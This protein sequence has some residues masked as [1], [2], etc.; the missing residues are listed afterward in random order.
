MITFP[1]PTIVTKGWGYEVW[2]HNDFD[3]CGKILHFEE[4]KACS[5]HL[6][7]R[8][9]ETWYVLSGLF[10]LF[11]TDPKTGEALVKTLYPKDVI[12]V[13]QGCVHRLYCVEA[14]DIAEFSTE[15]RDDD[16][17]RIDGGDSQKNKT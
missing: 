13:P 14:G 4:D 16:S 11:Y 9:I 12:E 2:I 8:K 5:Y 15:H 17:F 7:V 6:H 3:Y 1:K 10:T